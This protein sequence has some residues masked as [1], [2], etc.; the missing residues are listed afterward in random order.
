MSTLDASSI[1]KVVIACDAGMG[2]S[3]MLAGQLSSSLAPY[4]VSVQHSPVNQ[5]PPDADLVVCQQSLVPR[6]RSVAPDKAVLGFTMFL[7]DPVFERLQAA[8][9][10][11]GDLEY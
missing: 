4:S 5:I 2:S 1:K 7:G 6:A 9:R 8:I 10:D 3:V 11:G